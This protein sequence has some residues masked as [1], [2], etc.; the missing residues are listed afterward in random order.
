VHDALVAQH[1]RKIAESEFEAA[2]NIVHTRYR[3]Q[4]RED[5]PQ[6]REHEQQ[7]DGENGECK[8]GTP[9]GGRDLAEHWL[10]HH[11]HG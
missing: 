10:L 1:L 4:R 11:A 2:M 7:T 6:H 9:R 8:K 5:E 3:P